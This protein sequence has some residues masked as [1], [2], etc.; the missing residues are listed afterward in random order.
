MSALNHLA[1]T[2]TLHGRRYQWK[3][4]SHMNRKQPA[5]TASHASRRSGDRKI[6]CLNQRH[7]VSTDLPGMIRVWQ[8][9]R[10]YGL[11]QSVGLLAE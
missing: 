10:R 8:T 9:E 6:G 7:A 2:L 11:R 3:I 5:S 4:T 1:L